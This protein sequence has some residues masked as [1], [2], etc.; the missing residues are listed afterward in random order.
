MLKF[1][2]KKITRTNSVRGVV[3]ERGM[4][5]LEL[6]VVMGIFAAISST[7]LFNYRNFSNNVALQNLAQDIALQIKQAQ[8]DAIS[9]RIP[10]LPAGTNQGLNSPSLLPGDWKPSYGI[11]FRLDNENSWSLGGK[12]FVYY[13]NSGSPPQPDQP[14]I[15]RD[16]DDFFGTYSGCDGD[17][18]TSECLQE[19]RITSGDM[20]DMI[21]FDFE[22]IDPDCTNGTTDTEAY[23]SFTRP[24]GNAIIMDGTQDDGGA[25]PHE[26]V[27]IR[28]SSPSGKHKYVSVWASGYISVR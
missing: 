26:S 18:D 19:I 10:V 25:S 5:A 28:V 13:F 1:L 6:V 27:F 4:T 17:L 22:P 7:V 12:G 24:R 15:N 21:C 20:I 2:Q 8:T 11:A 23:I 14:E 3:P 16:F 9:G